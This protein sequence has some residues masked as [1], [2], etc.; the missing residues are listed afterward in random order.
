MVLHAREDVNNA[1]GVKYGAFMNAQIDREI[2]RR[3]ARLKRIFDRFTVL[4]LR[5]FAYLPLSTA[6]RLRL[7]R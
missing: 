1:L 2:R 7:C 5:H 3:P 6:R 4:A